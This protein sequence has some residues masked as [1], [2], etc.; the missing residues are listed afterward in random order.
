MKFKK[1]IIII[2]DSVQSFL[3]KGIKT[4]LGESYE[5]KE[6]LIETWKKEYLLL[7]QSVNLSKKYD[8]VILAPSMFSI[9]ENNYSNHTSKL[10]NDLAFDISDVSSLF[11][12]NNKWILKYATN[13]SDNKYMSEIISKMFSEVLINDKNQEIALI[14][15]CT[16]LP[17]GLE[18]KLTDLR[19]WQSSS[20]EIHPEHSAF[21]SKMLA[22]RIL[23]Q[24]RII[25]CIIFDLDNT[26]WSGLAGEQSLEEIEIGG[27]VYNNCYLDI[28]KWLKWQKE[29]GVLLAICSKNE[30][31]TALKVFKNHPD[32]HLSYNDIA[33]H[34]I[35]WEDKHVN[36]ASIAEQLN[37][38]LNQIL[39]LDDQ[40]I[41]REQVK[42]FLPHVLVVDISEDPA[43]S[44]SA[45]WN[46]DIL[47]P[48]NLT[49]ED[50]RRTE[51]YLQE[52]ERLK[53]SAFFTSHLEFLES[54]KMKAK[55]EILSLENV[56]RAEQLC[57]RTNQFNFRTIRFNR[58]DLEGII[59]DPSKSSFLI[60]L[61]DKFGK[62]GSVVLVIL[63]KRSNEI[64]IENWLMSCR[65]F[66]RSL[67]FFTFNHIIKLA[68]QMKCDKLICEYLPTD[69]NIYIKE[70]SGK[71]GFRKEGVEQNMCLKKVRKFDTAIMEFD[72]D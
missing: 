61:E 31:N 27:G 38:G 53:N 60:K 51:M 10:N 24:T 16:S 41:E 32:M 4:K 36:I 8:F 50:L 6:V 56:Q 33:S 2:S 68:K 12:A 59:N 17:V 20:I 14:D 22:D 3:C 23:Y 7:D 21:L 63:E 11:N 70:L 57:L 13:I 40:A 9:Y 71:L 62:Y 67:E 28:Q 43:D 47:S 69:K 39:F 72:E 34:R 1:K 18:S 19:L 42:A 54:L 15:L 44:L 45:I 26:I 37:L 64:F 5:V 66:R 29:K 30:E 58:S 49:E 25:K 52:R 48:L 65:V 46:L 35:N 55:V